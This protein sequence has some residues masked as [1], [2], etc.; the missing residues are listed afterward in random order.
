MLVHDNVQERQSQPCG[1][2]AHDWCATCNHYVCSQ[3]AHS[4][5]D[6]HVRSNVPVRLT[7]TQRQ[8]L[9]QE[10]HI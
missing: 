8:N 9:K 5:H 3:H 2:R 10:Y 4:N 1:L 7:A 6:S